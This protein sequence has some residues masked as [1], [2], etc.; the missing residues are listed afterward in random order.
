M[1]VQWERC[2]S[3]QHG[4]SCEKKLQ[5]L[6]PAFCLVTKPLIPVSGKPSHKI[7]ENPDSWQR[8]VRFV[9]DLGI[10]SHPSLLVMCVKRHLFVNARELN[11]CFS[12]NYLWVQPN[13][14][15]V[16][17][18][19]KHVPFCSPPESCLSEKFHNRHTV[20]V[21]RNFHAGNIQKCGCQVNV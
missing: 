13:T 4:S 18:K 19:L 1:T 9:G 15:I 8:F 5:K 21:L 14:H 10:S 7:I 2:P 3:I 20:H 12:D 17:L 11:N 16:I 6:P